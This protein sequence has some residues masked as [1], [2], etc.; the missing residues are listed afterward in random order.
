MRAERQDGRILDFGPEMA[1]RCSVCRA[2][3]D[4]CPASGLV[5]MPGSDTGWDPCKA[6]LAI[7]FGREQKVIDS[8]WPWVCT[9]CGRC[10]YQCPMG[11]PFV[12]AFHACRTARKRD[13]VPGPI[14]RGT[15]MNLEKGN[16]LGIPRDDFLSLLAELG[17]EMENDE[18]QPCPGFYV[19]VDREGANVIVT[20]NSKEVFSEQD[21]LKFWWRIFYAAQE[22]WTVSS[23]NWDGV[24]WGLF[25]GDDASMKMQVERVIANARRLKVKTILYPECGHAYYA[26]RFGFTN[27]FP[28]VFGEFRVVSVL[29][30][31]CEYLRSGR[32]KVNKNKIR[33][34]TTVHDCCSYKRKSQMTFGDHY[35]EI[36]RWIVKQCL[37]ESLL[38]EMCDDP[39][40][41]ICC[42]A[43][44]GAWAMPYTEERLAYGKVKADQIRKTGAEL[45]IASC[46]NCRDQIKKAL[47]KVYDLGHYQETMYVWEL[48][49]NCLKIEPWSGAEIQT[50]H[51]ARDA[52]FERYG[53][54]LKTENL[55]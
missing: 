42:G 3:V 15:M 41:N 5:P 13:Q 30:L 19:P 31:L 50:A 22:D 4:V 1:D 26:T 35:A 37:E 23:V 52:Q 34:V 14:H 20:I 24:N 16:N 12:K 6:V 7:A 49:A 48:V 54:E 53:I 46:H 36:E 39:L 55:Y 44:G 2:C 40:N 29:D 17:V 38:R 45:V 10:Q 28:E 25:G 32:I 21:D 9:L 47:P 8:K 43:A 11:V 18:E 27:W 33:Q 51:V